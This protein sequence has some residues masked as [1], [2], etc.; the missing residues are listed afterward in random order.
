MKRRM[1]AAAR[2]TILLV[3]LSKFEVPA[4]TRL[5]EVTEVDQVI[6]DDEIP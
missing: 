6:T 1:I 3:D 2:R 5:C 4:L